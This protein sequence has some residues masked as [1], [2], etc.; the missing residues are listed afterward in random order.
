MLQNI[1]EKFTGW[2]AISILALI[3]VTFIFVGG[4]NFAFIG[5]NYAA[6]VDDVPVRS[7]LSR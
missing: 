3:G 5:S 6:K 4:A 1:R 7:R 2:I